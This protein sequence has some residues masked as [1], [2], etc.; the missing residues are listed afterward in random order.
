[1]LLTGVVGRDEHEATLGNLRERKGVVYLTTCKMAVR[2]RMEA[3]GAFGVLQP[4]S[5]MP[6]AHST[7]NHA[8]ARQP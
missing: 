6:S 5:W 3:M 8:L 2:Q 7:A 1:M 4:T